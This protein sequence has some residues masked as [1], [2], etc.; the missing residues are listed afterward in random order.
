MIDI[1]SHILPYDD[2]PSTLQKSL[3]IAE[4]A[5]K[6]GITDIVYTPHFSSPKDNNISIFSAEFERRIEEFKAALSGKNIPLKIV[7]GVENYITPELPECV[8]KKKEL[9]TINK[10]AKYLLF[11]VS[12]YS[13]PIFIEQVIFDLMSMGITPIIAHIERNIEFSEN[14]DKIKRLIDMG[15][16]TQVNANSLIGAYGGVIKKIAK[17]FLRKGLVTVLAGD[18]H[19]LSHNSFL[20]EG[21]RVAEKIVG[22]NNVQRMVDDIPRNIINGENVT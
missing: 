5:V 22:K 11:E 17:N 1:H 8:E 13:I 20:T 9:F 12:F 4:A 14:D 21:M 2:G 16:L 10:N 18:V 3:T 15:C 19:Q 7:Y 6:E